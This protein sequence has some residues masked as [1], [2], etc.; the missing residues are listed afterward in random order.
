MG[1]SIQG[2]IKYKGPVADHGWR[3]E[4]TARKPVWLEPGL[5]GIDLRNKIQEEQ[6]LRCMPPKHIPLCQSQ[7]KV[8]HLPNFHILKMRSGYFSKK[9]KKKGISLYFQENNKKIGKKKK[10][11]YKRKGKESQH[12]CLGKSPKLPVRKMKT[13][14]GFELKLP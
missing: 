1:K 11:T 10:P 13:V 14:C 5:V 7:R 12:I 9:K 2:S 8:T 4:E 6:V 3:V